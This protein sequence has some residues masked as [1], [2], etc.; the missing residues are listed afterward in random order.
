MIPGQQQQISNWTLEQL[1][2][3]PYQH[4]L[5][6]GFGPGNTLQEVARRLKVGFL[7]GIDDSISMYRQAYRRNLR[8]IRQ[9]LMQLH[10]GS[11]H[12]LSY[13]PHYFHTIYGS[14]A[15]SR[16]A[17]PQREIIRL[18]NLLKTGG[19][20]VMV[21]QPPGAR[22]ET[23]IR[24]AVGKIEED[25]VAAGLTDIRIRYMDTHF[26]TCISVTGYKA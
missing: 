5:E 25:Y 26:S 10:F 17:D 24:D 14:N 13:P 21:F 1:N 9:Q 19:R 18:S 23:D 2:V 6:V 22:H 8:Y 15:I 4:L 12:E 11:L 7:A 20:L 3:Q 16:W